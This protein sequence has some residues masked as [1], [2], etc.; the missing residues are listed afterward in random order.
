MPSR[1]EHVVTADFRVFFFQLFLLT[2]YLDFWEKKL[3]VRFLLRARQTEHPTSMAGNEFSQEP[4]SPRGRGV[5]ASQ[6]KSEKATTI[7]KRK[8]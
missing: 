4:S 1:Q 7:R 5:T 8:N 3:S 6:G 2:T